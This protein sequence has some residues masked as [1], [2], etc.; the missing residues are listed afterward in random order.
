MVTSGIGHSFVWIL[1]SHL[2]PAFLPSL[3]KQALRE[4]SLSSALSR[5]NSSSFV[6]QGP[7]QAPTP[8]MLVNAANAMLAA[9]SSAGEHG[10]ADQ[11]WQA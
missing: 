8:A 2:L 7:F 10:L 3:P 9:A 11:G 4:R 5:A 1:A 6:A